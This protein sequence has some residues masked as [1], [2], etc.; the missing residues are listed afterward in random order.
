MPGR[1]QE[2]RGFSK[3]IKGISRMISKTKVEHRS[4]LKHHIRLRVKGT[5]ERPRLTVY[6]SLLHIYAQ[7]IDDTSGTTL[8]SVSDL[9]K[10]VKE[11][12]KDVKGHI[13]VSKRV[14][15]MAAKRALEKN[16]TQVVFDRNG[17]LYH[18]VVKAL[19]EG[20]RAG[21]LKF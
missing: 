4:R 12:L 1:S 21:G 18:G 5:Q 19:A 8:I 3:R 6:R 16:I 20:A 17:Y 10:D 14:G 11:Q 2:A 9:S 15:E 7:I 13:A